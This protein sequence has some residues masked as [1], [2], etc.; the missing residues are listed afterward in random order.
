LNFFYVE[1]IVHYLLF[2]EIVVF[3]ANLIMNVIILLFASC[4]NVKKLR[5]RR[6]NREEEG[7]AAAPA[8]APLNDRGD[9]DEI[10]EEKEDGGDKDG[11]KN[12]AKNPE[13]GLQPLI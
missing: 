1:D 13:E 6:D 3:V 9:G 7:P 10:E 5:K 11:P 2:T 12:G 8:G 4:F